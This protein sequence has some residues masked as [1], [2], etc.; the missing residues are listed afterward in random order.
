LQTFIECLLRAAVQG[1]IVQRKRGVEDG[2]VRLDRAQALKVLEFM[3][4]RKRRR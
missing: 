4:G 1:A 2:H 3:E